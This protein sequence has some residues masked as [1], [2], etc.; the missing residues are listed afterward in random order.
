MGRAARLHERDVIVLGIDSHYTWQ[1]HCDG[2]TTQWAA[3][4]NETAD[5]LARRGS[6]RASVGSFP[7]QRW[8]WILAMARKIQARITVFVVRAPVA[9]LTMSARFFLRVTIVL[10][11]KFHEKAC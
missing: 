2:L 6:D 7:A 10:R 3:A 4:G 11:R 5:V 8:Q 1:D 9:A